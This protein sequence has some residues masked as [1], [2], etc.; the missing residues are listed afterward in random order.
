MAHGWVA[1]QL[2]HRTE[3]TGVHLVLRLN[4]LTPTAFLFRR[5]PHFGQRKNRI[6]DSASKQ[7]T[8]MWRGAVALSTERDRVAN[9]DRTPSPENSCRPA[10]P[11]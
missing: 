2:I 10:A 6:G 9:A 5:P 11:R 4:P 8:T 7:T 1:H 3:R